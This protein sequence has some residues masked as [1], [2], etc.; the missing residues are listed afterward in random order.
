MIGSEPKLNIY[1][2]NP[3]KQYMGVYMDEHFYRIKVLGWAQAGVADQLSSHYGQD[4]S[5]DERRVWPGILGEDPIQMQM[6]MSRHDVF[7]IFLRAVNITQDTLTF[8]VAHYVALSALNHS[9]LGINWPFST[10]LI[11]H[12][13]ITNIISFSYWHLLRNQAHYTIF[14]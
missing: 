8:P 12:D 10:Y 13:F 7:N 11:L 9:S 3:L 2:K 5:A 6:Q 14:S 4:R 1:I